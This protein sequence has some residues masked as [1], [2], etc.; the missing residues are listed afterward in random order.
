MP[1]PVRVLRLDCRDAR[2]PARG[3]CTRRATPPRTVAGRTDATRPRDRRGARSASCP[4]RAPPRRGRRWR[5]RRASRPAWSARVS[6][7]PTPWPSRWQDPPSDRTARGTRR[8]LDS[9]RASCR[10][11]RLRKPRRVKHRQRQDADVGG[12][13]QE[14]GMRA[15]R[16]PRRRRDAAHRPRGKP[17]LAKPTGPSPPSD[18]GIV[19]RQRRRRRK[20]GI[21]T[22]PAPSVPRSMH[23][24]RRHGRGHPAR[25]ALPTSA[26]RRAGRVPAR[27]GPRRGWPDWPGPGGGGAPRRRDAGGLNA[28]AGPA[29]TGVDSLARLRGTAMRGDVDGGV[30][31]PR[32]SSAVPRPLGS[33]SGRSRALVARSAP[34]RPASPRPEPPPGPRG[35]GGER[36]VVRAALSPMA[37]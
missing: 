34:P 14:V 21:S 22:G 5:A 2:P 8:G 23:D 12:P 35:A 15:D 20:A 32:G 24:A 13:T 7:A 10:T 31:D 4:A 18:P 11:S 3:G 16:S 19:G 33:A 37:L 36:R 1:T 25:R 6:R 30:V 26:S 28:H 17:A 29:T 9:D 27:H